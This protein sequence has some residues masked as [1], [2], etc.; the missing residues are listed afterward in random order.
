MHNV[1]THVAYERVA[2]KLSRVSAASID[3][4]TRR[5]SEVA[6]GVFRG[7]DAFFAIGVERQELPG[8]LFIDNQFVALGGGPPLLADD[9]P[10]FRRTGTENACTGPIRRNAANGIRDGLRGHGGF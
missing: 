10:G 3:G 6:D 8:P 9:P 4:D 1:A 5:R 2:L 7:N